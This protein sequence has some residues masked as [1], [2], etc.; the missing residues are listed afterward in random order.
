MPKVTTCWMKN[1]KQS[2][3]LSLDVLHRVTLNVGSPGAASPS[4]TCRQQRC[5][6]VHFSLTVKQVETVPALKGVKG[7]S[8]SVLTELSGI[9]FDGVRDTTNSMSWCLQAV[10]LLQMEHAVTQVPAHSCYGKKEGYSCRQHEL[11]WRPWF[12]PICEKQL[13]LKWKQLQI[14]RT[15]LTLRFKCW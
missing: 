5:A 8:V 13:K 6:Q 9:A 11:N 4:A 7:L 10:R 1:T 15:T 12:P 14:T 2:K 3:H